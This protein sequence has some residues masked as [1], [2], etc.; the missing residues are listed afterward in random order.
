MKHLTCW[1]RMTLRSAPMMD[2]LFFADC[3]GHPIEDFA[4]GSEQSN[5]AGSSAVD[6]AAA[7]SAG[8]MT[9]MESTPSE[10][11]TRPLDAD[12]GWNRQ[13]AGHLLIHTGHRVK[14]F[15]G[16]LPHPPELAS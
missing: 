13:L 10:T 9:I 5:P 1:E 3:N 16:Q 12:N 7:S 6:G 15:N 8:N 11:E 2:A 4:G 14:I